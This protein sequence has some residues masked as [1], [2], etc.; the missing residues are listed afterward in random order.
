[1]KL[2]IRTLP[3]FEPWDPSPNTTRFLSRRILAS[4]PA[5]NLSFRFPSSL[6]TKVITNS[7]VITPRPPLNTRVDRQPVTD[8]S[9]I[10]P[11]RPKRPP[12]SNAELMSPTLV[13][14]FPPRN[15]VISTTDGANTSAIPTPTMKRKIA[16]RKTADDTEV[17]STAKDETRIPSDTVLLGPHFAASTPPGTCIIPT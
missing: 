6:G 15:L 10:H 12:T 3:R 4:L 9:R 16:T 5:E 2:E 14:D 7:A 8:A 17:P 11:K 13:P 1:M